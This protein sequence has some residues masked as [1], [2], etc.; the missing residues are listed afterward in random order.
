MFFYVIVSKTPLNSQSGRSKQGENSQGTNSENFNLYNLALIVVGHE[1][2]SL[3]GRSLPT[4]TDPWHIS[5]IHPITNF[6]EHDCVVR[7]P[8]AVVELGALHLPP[9]TRRLL[10]PLPCHHRL[11]LQHPS[12]VS[13]THVI[14]LTFSVAVDASAR[15]FPGSSPASLRLKWSKTPSSSILRNKPTMVSLNRNLRSC[16]VEFAWRDGEDTGIALRQ[17]RGNVWKRYTD[18]ITGY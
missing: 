3:N 13:S 12:S 5:F 11:F 10:R 1:W 4:R 9:R 2:L 6:S 7:A 14:Y 15:T 18:S 16:R 8:S 17:Q